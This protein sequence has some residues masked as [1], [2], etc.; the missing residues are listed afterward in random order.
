MINTRIV[1]TIV[2]I[3]SKTLLP[4]ICVAFGF[5]FRLKRKTKYNMVAVILIRKNIT[6]ENIRI[7]SLSTPCTKFEAPEN[8]ILV[9]AV[10]II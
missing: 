3:I 10:N 1:G 4:S 8:I 6:T 2:Q 5:D 7:K 9:L